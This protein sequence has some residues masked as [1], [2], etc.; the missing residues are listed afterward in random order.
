MAARSGSKL[1]QELADPEY[2]LLDL[3]EVGPLKGWPEAALAKEAE[4][5]VGAGEA[6][7]QQVDRSSTPL[8]TAALNG[9]PSVVRVLLAH[10]AS[11]SL[12]NRWKDDALS[13]AKQGGNTEVL[14]LITAARS[15]AGGGAATS[16]PATVWFRPVSEAEYTFYP[17]AR[18]RRELGRTD[19]DVGFVLNRD[20]VLEL[21]PTKA[22]TSTGGVTTITLDEGR[23]TLRAKEWESLSEAEVA[24]LRRRSK[25]VSMHDINRV[26]A[27]YGAD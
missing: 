5:R 24:A 21:Q 12:K 11:P 8:M 23:L 6:V 10:G 27:E 18:L 9:W 1:E 25:S 13:C 22:P 2:T 19:P 14:A 16:A 3:L 15:Q 26:V 7:D 4:R 20:E 17:S